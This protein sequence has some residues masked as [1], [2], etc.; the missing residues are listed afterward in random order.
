[1]SNEK[2]KMTFEDFLQGITASNVV[3]ALKPIDATG[4]LLGSG[5]THL[6]TN[7]HL[8]AR[9]AVFELLHSQQLKFLPKEDE[10]NKEYW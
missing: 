6:L 7:A 9:N 10:E 1:M 8:E 2:W 4:E 3:A 5:T